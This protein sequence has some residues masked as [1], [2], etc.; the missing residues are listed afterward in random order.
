MITVLKARAAG[1]A[2]GEIIGERIFLKTR[3]G[4]SYNRTRVQSIA[5][6]YGRHTMAY[7]LSG[8]QPFCILEAYLSGFTLAFDN[9]WIRLAE[10]KTVASARTQAVGSSRGKAQGK[11]EIPLRDLIVAVA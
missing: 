8:K 3:G 1:R 9:M 2:H 7:M 11:P 10:T 6:H 5:E 4:S